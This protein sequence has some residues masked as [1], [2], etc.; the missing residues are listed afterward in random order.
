MTA[1]NNIVF[2]GFQ[3]R[4]QDGY[5]IRCG[6]PKIYLHRNIWE[7][8]HGPIPEGCV[9]HHVD[10]NPLNNKPDNLQCITRSEHNAIHDSAREPMQKVCSCCGKIFLAIVSTTEYC[11]GT[12]S[13]KVRYYNKRN[14]ILEKKSEY[15]QKN[16]ENILAN[17]RRY[18]IQNRATILN[19]RRNKSMGA[20]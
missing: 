20:D 6:V 11:S 1:P 3:Y 2:D 13:D 15:Y 12:C 19:R 10:F 8:L 17:K 16:R 9:I 4:I 18:Y 5:Y 7:K 14:E